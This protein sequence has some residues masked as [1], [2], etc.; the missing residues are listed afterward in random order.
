MKSQT[1]PQKISTKIFNEQAVV[2]A[3]K[4]IQALGDTVEII[5]PSK[6]R[7]A[8]IQAEIDYWEQ[9]PA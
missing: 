2:D 6:K 3:L 1:P 9:H 4:E 5:V 7:R 8:E